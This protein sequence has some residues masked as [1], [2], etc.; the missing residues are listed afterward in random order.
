M[1][2]GSPPQGFRRQQSGRA[3]IDRQA[4]LEALEVANRACDLARGEILPRFR[5]VEV[6][7]KSDG[8]P[9]TE[10]DRAAELAIRSV[11]ENAFPDDAILG[12]EF[13]ESGVSE[14]TGKA[15]RRRWIIDP[16]DGTIA[17]A[18]GIP[19]FAT[20]VALVVD[21]EP[22]MGVIDLP[23]IGDRIG[24]FRGGGLFRGEERL[25]VSNTRNLED[26][27]V[28]HGDLYCFKDA[29]LLPVFDRMAQT[30]PKLRGYT[31]AFG[32]LLVLSGAADAMVDCGLRPWDAAVARILTLEAGGTCWVR[33]REDGQQLDLV[34]GNNAILEAL[35]E[36]F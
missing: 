18:R 14:K 11:I 23:A 6:E 8:S 20:L 7:T 12:E 26:A 30:I 5:N 15:P 21:D 19:L 31:D 1:K 35:G 27:L 29:G 34:I 17:F 4:L 2:A 28:C 22:V 10:A 9:V 24:G 3:E 13:G 36:L 25:S 32:H 16:I 33:E